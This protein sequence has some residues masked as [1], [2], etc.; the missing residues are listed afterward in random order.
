[1]RYLQ[2]LL[3]LAGVL[4]G[5]IVWTSIARALGETALRDNTPASPLPK[6]VVTG[7]LRRLYLRMALVWLSVL[8]GATLLVV[9][10]DASVGWRWFFGGAAV[11][12]LI[13]ALTILRALARVDAS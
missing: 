9:S 10:T 12:P 13:V 3:A 7:R 5:G 6:Q 8:G 2:P 4:A 11:V 1:M